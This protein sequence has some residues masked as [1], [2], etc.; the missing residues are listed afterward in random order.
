[1]FSVVWQRCLVTHQ[2][3]APLIGHADT[4]LGSQS[5]DVHMLVICRVYFETC[6]QIWRL[7]YSPDD[8]LLAS[9]SAD[10]TVRLWEVWLVFLGCHL[11]CE[12]PLA[13]AA[14]FPAVQARA[15]T[16]C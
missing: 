9:T 7:A 14:A 16:H 8:L 15:I 6:T 3:L 13:G 10:G 1:M 2:L 5:L 12:K 11:A 4:A